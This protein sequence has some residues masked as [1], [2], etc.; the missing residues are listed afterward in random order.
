MTVSRI[1]GVTDAT[2]GPTVA[3]P[4]GYHRLW[5]A[6]RTVRVR[7]EKTALWAANGTVATTRAAAVERRRATVAV[8][9]RHEGATRAP[10][11]PIDSVHERGGPLGGPNLRDIAARANAMVVDSGGGIDGLA[12]DAVRGSVESTPETVHGDRPAG[13][14]EWVYGDLV[15]LRERLRDVTVAV[16]RGRVGTF[17]ARPAAELAERLRANRSAYVDAPATYDGVAET[18]RVAARARLFERVVDELE[19]RADRRS[20]RVS[21]LRETLADGVASL[22]LLRDAY[23]ASRAADRGSTTDD[24]KLHVDGAPPYLTTAAVTHEAVPAVD[25]NATTHPLVA[26]NTNYATLPYADAVGAVTDA[27]LSGPSRRIR[28]GVAARSLRAADGAVAVSGNESLGSGGD[29]EGESATA[30]RTELRREVRATTQ[31]VAEDLQAPLLDVGVGD[32]PQDREQVVDGALAEWDSVSARALA[33]ANG[34]VVESVVGVARRRAGDDLEGA[35]AV[36]RLRLGLRSALRESLARREQKVDGPLVESVTKRIEGAVGDRL[37]DAVNETVEKRYGRVMSRLPAGIPVAPPVA[38]WYATV[39]V[40]SVTVRGE[41][42]RFAVE[43]PRRTPA[44][45][46]RQRHAGRRRR[47]R[48]RTAR[49]RDSRPVQRGDGR[50]GRRPRRRDGRRGHRRRANGAVGRLAPS[51]H[52]GPPLVREQRRRSGIR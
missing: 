19:A 33:V 11:R 13:I 52:R 20:S 40:W 15:E 42:E 47:R 10:D 48:G 23:D 4:E 29:T 9:G 51:R 44:A 17:E 7:H 50:R 46:R 3:T 18:A 21:T 12:A 32:S 27:A 28:L 34:S 8:V 6:Q 45:G 14:R 41:Y 5:A 37:E 31:A 49:R 25:P 39:N 2:S 22:S 24:L 16:E 35:Y 36:D 43:T 30:N 38:P 1:D 26:E